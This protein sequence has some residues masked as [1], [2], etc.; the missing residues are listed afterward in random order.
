M[1]ARRQR[2][3][4]RCQWVHAGVQALRHRPATSGNGGS[5]HARTRSPSLLPGRQ[6]GFITADRNAERD[7]TGTAPG[8][9]HAGGRQGDRRS[10]GRARSALTPHAGG[11][12]RPRGRAGTVAGSVPREQRPSWAGDAQAGASRIEAIMTELVPVRRGR[13]HLRF[14]ARA[15]DSPRS[16]SNTTRPTSPS[17]VSCRGAVCYDGAGL[18]APLMEE[19]V[20]GH[21]RPVTSRT[22]GTPRRRAAMRR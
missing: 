13:A 22:S 21:R 2:A 16:D 14:A 4:D 20:R 1:Q 9:A 15:R 10:A 18:Q 6:V 8:V 19:V 11:G 3:D 7:A 17:T 5:T 12:T